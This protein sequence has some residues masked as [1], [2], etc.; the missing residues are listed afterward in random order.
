[1]AGDVP[2]KLIDKRLIM[3]DMGTLV[4]GTKYR[5]EFES[6]LKS[7]LEEAADPTLGI[8]L[9][10]DEIHTLMGAGSGEGTA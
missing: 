3:L 8:I 9:F 1:M 2:E 6:R 4:A 5:G 7:I 10:I